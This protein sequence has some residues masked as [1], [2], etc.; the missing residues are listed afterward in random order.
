[1]YIRDLDFIIV[2]TNFEAQIAIC[3]L[4]PLI[5]DFFLHFLTC[6]LIEIL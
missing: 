1:M 5:F 2:E 3:S 4:T 6:C